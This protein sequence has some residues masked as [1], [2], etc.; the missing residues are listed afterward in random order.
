MVVPPE[1]FAPPAHPHPF[2]DI[3]VHRLDMEPGLVAVCAGYE[4]QKWRAS[5]LAAHM[6]EWLPDFA[7]RDSERQGLRAENAVSLIARAAQVVYASDKYERRGEAGELLL[8]IILRQVFKTIPAISKMFFKDSANDTVKG[9]DAVHVVAHEDTLQLWLGEAKFYDDI[10]RAIHDAVED[11]TAHFARDYMR[12]EFAAITNKI[13][14]AWPHGA[15]LA[16]LLNPNTSLDQVFDSLCVPVLLTYD[17]PVVAAH[18]EVTAAFEDAFRA[19][20]EKHHASFSSKRPPHL[21]IHLLLLPMNRKDNLVREFDERL[22][23]AQG[24]L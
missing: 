2:L 12:A 14:G 9:F 18:G 17:S 21:T 20:V 8:H 7:L 19:E 1:V 4:Q 13:D 23:H 16:K 22:K 3:R 5:R 15:T 6:I 11:L 10:A 24:I